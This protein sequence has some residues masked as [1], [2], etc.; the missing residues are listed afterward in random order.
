MALLEELK[1]LAKV[2]LAPHPFITIYLNTKWNSEKQRERVRIFAKSKLRDLL[3]QNEDRSPEAR[4]SLEEDAERIDQYIRGLVSREHDEDYA[5]I[6]IFSCS[7]MGVYRVIKSYTP[8]EQS[9]ECC[10]RPALRPALQAAKAGAPALLCIIQGDSGRLVE[11]EL[12]GIRREF[13]FEDEE[14][15]GRHEQ[16]GWSQARFQRHVREHLSRNLTKLSEQA[17]RWLDESRITRFLLSGPEADVALFETFLPKRIVATIRGRLALDPNATRDV[18]EAE[19]RAA[20]ESARAEDDAKAVDEVLDGLGFGRAAAGADAVAE[21]VTAGKIRTL[22]LEDRFRQ[23]GWKC[24]GCGALGVKV[25]LGCPVCHVAV[26]AVELGEELVRGTLARDGD[27]VPIR[28]HEG[29]RAE[30]GVAALLRYS[31][32]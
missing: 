15:P 26:E 4:R 7:G 32:K 27:V 25:P 5:G 29:L 16:G 3:A 17:I 9:F 1:E 2:S 12:G 8:F 11:F 18:I 24:F 6:A 19:V 30:G 31:Q 10:S 20:L 21:A 22:Y 28:E 13:A 14:F 23:P